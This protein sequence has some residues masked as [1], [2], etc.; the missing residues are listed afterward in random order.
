MENYYQLLGLSTDATSEEIKQRCLALGQACRPDKHKDEIGAQERFEK[1]EKA[2]ATLT[3]PD[4]RA[5]Y[6]AMIIGKGMPKPEADSDRPSD[7]QSPFVGAAALA[8]G[9]VCA[10]FSYLLCVS[11]FKLSDIEKTLL[12]SAL[13]FLA[14][15]VPG[16]LAYLKGGRAILWLC[17][18]LVLCGFLGILKANHERDSL[19]YRAEKGRLEAIEWDKLDRE[20]ARA[21]RLAEEYDRQRRR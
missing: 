19:T 14:A 2:F 18:F 8:I 7:D 15:L 16:V 20:K 9:I 11:F 21:S 10:V 4:S 3:N 13:I 1:I 5:A 17:S 6:D 12:V